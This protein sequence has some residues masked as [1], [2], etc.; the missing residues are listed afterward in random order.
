MRILVAGALICL[1][2]IG[3]AVA[4]QPF[5]G[6]VRLTYD[7]RQIEGKPLAWTSSMVYLLGRGGRLWQFPPDEATDFSKT[8]SRFRSYTVSELRAELLR[9]LGNRFEVTGTGHYLVAHPRGQRDIWPQR[10]E[11]L[12]RSFVHYFSVRGFKPQKPPYLLI[13]TVCG[14]QREFM[15]ISANR[16]ARVTS[17]VLG[18]YGPASNQILLYDVYAGRNPNRRNPDNWQQNA[19]VIIHEAA[20]QTAFNT[21]IHSRYAPPP[22]WV[23]EGLATMFEAPGVYDSRYHTDRSDRVNRGRLQQFRQIVAKKHRPEVLQSIV[24][25]DDLFRTHAAAAYAEAWALSFFLVET[26]PRQ[27][28]KYLALTAARPAF[29]DY[30][31][32]ERTAD[33]TS[34]FGTNWKML[35]ARFLRFMAEVN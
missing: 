32:S 13:G 27:Y 18:F 33:F 10:F 3:D 4:A 7:D 15:Q 25:S 11:D 19:S 14:N 8:S 26:R 29:T 31:S 21:G 17:G 5:E 20:H 1:C 9:E 2:C 34:V 16:G 6:M 30:T 35:D 24:A 22:L 28:T 12:Y 23:A